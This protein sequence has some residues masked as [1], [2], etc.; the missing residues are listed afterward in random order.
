[1]ETH[2]QN[3]PQLKVLQL[4]LPSVIFRDSSAVEQEAVNFEVAGSNPVPGAKEIESG[5]YAWL[6]FF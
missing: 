5:I 6:Y 1:M 3:L 2:L 4:G